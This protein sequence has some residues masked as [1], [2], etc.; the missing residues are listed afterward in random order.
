MKKENIING[1]IL[2]LARLKNSVSGNP[3]WKFI[4]QSGS[5][6]F[7]MK[8]ASSA[9]Y[10]F[11]PYTYYSTTIVYHVTRKGNL[12]CDDITYHGYTGIT[13]D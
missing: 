4:I 1:K 13:S 8:T 3:R 2:Q 11:L 10:K 12:I 9:G 5:Q 7:T 6:L